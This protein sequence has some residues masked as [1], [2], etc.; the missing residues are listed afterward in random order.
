MKHLKEFEDYSLKINEEIIQGPK[1]DPYEYKKD[2]SSY[3]TRKKGAPNWILTK[4]N[5]AKSIE[6]KIF[7]DAKKST[8][9]IKN[10][11]FKP[12]TFSQSSTDPVSSQ[13]DTFEPYAQ[14]N[15]AQK[16]M[17]ELKSQMLSRGIVPMKK[18]SGIDPHF[19]IFGDFLKLRKD[20]ITSKDFTKEELETMK[21]MIQKSKPGYQS[22]VVNFPALAGIDF[23]NVVRG[24][25]AQT[26]LN[27]KKSIAYVLGNS[28]VTDKGNYYQV[29]DIYDFN[30][31]YQN[32]QSYSIEKMPSLL[33]TAIKKIFSGNLVQGVEEISSYYHK[34][35]YKGIPVLID[36]PKNIA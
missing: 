8:A 13:R 30:N 23:K 12:Y 31:Y 27:R 21:E 25:E 17:G 11:P 15:L 5:V 1:G 2:G 16:Q 28:S 9:Q 10:I 29:K 33:S 7:S 6:D 24:T 35:G 32:P 18:E 34:M 36:I 4:G 26:G 3:Y 14:Q 19:R 22:K 20:P